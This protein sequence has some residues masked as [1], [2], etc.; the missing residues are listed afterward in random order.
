MDR[1]LRLLVP[2]VPLVVFVLVLLLVDDPKKPWSGIAYVSAVLTVVAIGWAI[3]R[4][5]IAL[6][7]LLAFGVGVLF[8]RDDPAAD[9]LQASGACD[10]AC[11]GPGGVGETIGLLGLFLGSLMT[12]G[13][14]LRWVTDRIS[15][16]RA[17]KR[18]G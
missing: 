17:S 2:A 15:K 8:S 10:P 18:G 1:R 5:V 11:P 13:V 16:T 14:A 3:G 6:I 12:I 4:W 9:R 7:P